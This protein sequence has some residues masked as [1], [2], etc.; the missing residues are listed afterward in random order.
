M[1]DE[2]KQQFSIMFSGE[3]NPFYGRH[4]TEETKKILREKHIGTSASEETRKKLSEINKERMKGP[5]DRAACGRPH[6]DEWK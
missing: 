3:G 6:T 5:E 2:Q 4:H 1:S